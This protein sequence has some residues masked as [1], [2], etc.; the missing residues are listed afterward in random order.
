DA[1]LLNSLSN[2]VVLTSPAAGNVAAYRSLSRNKILG[3]DSDDLNCE[4]TIPEI[5]G[6]STATKTLDSW[7]IGIDGIVD[8]ERKYHTGNKVSISDDTDLY[9][10]FN[11]ITYDDD[12]TVSEDSAL[13]IRDIVPVMYNG[14][15]HYT[16]LEVSDYTDDAALLKYYRS[17]Y[18]NAEKTL[19]SDIKLHIYD[20][21]KNPLLEGR[22]YTVAYK[23]NVN[24][25]RDVTVD[26]KRPQLII[27]YKGDYAGRK[28][29]TVYYRINPL[30]IDDLYE[31][32]LS[33]TAIKAGQNSKKLK[34]TLTRVPTTTE[35]SYGYC[36]DALKQNKDFKLIVKDNSGNLYSESEALAKGDYTVTVSGQGNYTG[37]TQLDSN[38]DPLRL[39]VYDAKDKSLKKASGVK[40][41]FIEPDSGKNVYNYSDSGVR[42]SISVNYKNQV[43]DSSQYYIAYEYI[44][45]AGKKSLTVTFKSSSDFCGAKK[46]AYTVLGE[47]IAKQKSIPSIAFTGSTDVKENITLMEKTLSVC[48]AAG[49]A[50]EPGTDYYVSYSKKPSG[51]FILPG[52]YSFKV[53]G[54]GKYSGRTATYKVRIDKAQLT[55]SN[56]T[57]HKKGGTSTSIGSQSLNIEETYTPDGATPQIM[58]HMD[59]YSQRSDSINSF[60]DLYELVTFKYKKNKKIGT[61]TV[62]VKAKSKYAT[63]TG[64]NIKNGFRV[65]YSIVAQPITKCSVSLNYIASSKY[66][67]KGAQSLAAN[68][69]LTVTDS[70]GNLLKYGRDYKGELSVSEN[71]QAK[72]T[73]TGAGN[74]S[75]TTSK[76]GVTIKGSLRDATVKLIG[77]STLAYTG[78][79]IRPKVE[80]TVPLYDEK[81]K[82]TGMSDPLTEGVDYKLSYCKKKSILQYE[83]ADATYRGRVYITVTGLPTGSYGGDNLTA[84]KK[85]SYTIK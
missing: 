27:T 58:L 80:V 35:Y 14:N 24:S 66:N 78:R 71:G 52:T 19:N 46:A 85:V 16:Y 69:L 10:I 3:F 17:H 13:V 60:G 11:T 7:Y 62:E 2:K 1:T 8:S 42:P 30:A 47:K 29:D 57:Y 12:T 55:P 53:I 67:R 45:D 22:D 41:T 32:K 68:N 63:I 82:K 36:S 6:I 34:A 50:M 70:N 28:K 84:R 73:L 75:G 20:S 44:K 54:R 43:V 64:G 48:S 72:V 49:S 33:T 38:Y 37:Y 76:N 40:I 56:F 4:Y 65:N 77:S 21:D 83:T 5:S 61:A 59:E 79:A 23:N 39:V 15:H 51:G 81:G 9:A 74:Y 31:A 25:S 26:K 18:S